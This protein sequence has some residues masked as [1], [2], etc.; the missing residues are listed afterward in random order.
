MKYSKIHVQYN[1]TVVSG[2]GIEMTSILTIIL[3]ATIGLL[4]DGRQQRRQKL[5]P[6]ESKAEPSQPVPRLKYT[7]RTIEFAKINH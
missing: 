5:W 2:P 7:T 6:H 1:L 3:T 4:G